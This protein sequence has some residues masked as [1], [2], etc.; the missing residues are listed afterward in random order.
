LL[1]SVRNGLSRTSTDWAPAP[2]AAASRAIS[3]TEVVVSRPAIARAITA[4]APAITRRRP[5][6]SDRRLVGK[7]MTAPAS[8]LAVAMRPIVGRG[9]PSEAR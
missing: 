4:I 8:E 1:C 7:A 5:I 2:K 3:T 9:T 6:R